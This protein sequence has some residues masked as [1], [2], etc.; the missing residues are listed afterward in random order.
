VRVL[1]VKRVGSFTSYVLAAD[2][3]KALTGWLAKNGFVTSHET[4]PWLRRYVELG[5]FYVAM[6]YDPPSGR[7]N[8]EHTSAETVRISFDTP[9]AYYPY[10]EP[11]RPAGR[12]GSPRM[13]DLWYVSQSRAVPVALHTL[14]ESSAWV[15][16]MQAGRQFSTNAPKLIERGFGPAR[17]LLPAAPIF[18]QRFIDQKQSR[19]GYGDVLFLP[20]GPQNPKVDALRRFF[21]ILDPALSPRKEPP[22]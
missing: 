12:A 18:I 8:P 20:D 17:E 14:G 9:I 10:F 5:F 4:E 22:P 11:D 1:E 21:P 13:L 19:T 7:P 15:R 2:D 6:R 3:E 16:P